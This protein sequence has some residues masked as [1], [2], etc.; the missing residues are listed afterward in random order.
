M[1]KQSIITR[2]QSDK[3]TMAAAA[4]RDVPTRSPEDFNTLQGARLWLERHA[5]R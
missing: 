4:Y 1:T 2:W 3:S 5:D